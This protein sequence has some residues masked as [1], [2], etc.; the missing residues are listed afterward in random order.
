MS[1]TCCALDCVGDS[2]HTTLRKFPGSKSLR[3]NCVPTVLRA[4]G[5]QK[6]HSLELLDVWDEKDPPVLTWPTELLGP[7]LKPVVETPPKPPPKM[8]PTPLP[9]P[10]FKLLAEPAPKAALVE[11]VTAEKQWQFH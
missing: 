4:N 7:P 10:A 11:T 1:K 2:T 5:C 9:V 6:A 8:P 3:A